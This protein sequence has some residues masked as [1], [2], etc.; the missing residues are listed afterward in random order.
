MADIVNWLTE[1][2]GY[3]FMQRGLTAAIIVG[4]VCAVLG[5]YI[6][7][8]GMAFFGDAL[9]HAILPGVAA[10]YLVGGGN[11]FWIFGGA[12]VA[13]V[14]TAFGIGVIS[15]G[16]LKEDTA[17]GVVFAGMFALGIAMIST[18]RSYTVDL[19]H[20]LFGNVLGVSNSDLWLISFFGGLVILTVLGLYKEFLVMSFDPLLATTLRL[21]TTFLRY[22]LL[23]LIAI[24]IVLSLQAVGIVL[25]TA[26]L[27]TP[28]AAAYLLTRRLPMMMALAATI[29]A[30]SGV[31]G[32]YLSFYVNIASGPAI[33]LVCTAFFL[34]ALLFSPHQ[35]LIKRLITT[36][37][38]SKVG[39]QSEPITAS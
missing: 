4:I 8:R 11:Q 34:I 13:G 2:L 6:V 16:V 26:M 5:T 19:T 24:T 38:A 15:K 25:V 3:A 39:E 22:L 17:I 27:V 18:V 33:V 14:F 9:A 32:L 20:F 10:G 21:P 36:R 28:A 12:L 23:L 7:L 35:G 37:Q 31:T 29:G 30:A 1:P